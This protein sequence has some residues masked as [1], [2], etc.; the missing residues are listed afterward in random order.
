MA[1]MITVIENVLEKCFEI[2]GE[3]ADK[4]IEYFS[5][6]IKAINGYW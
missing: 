4:K 3:E 2:L 5:Q 1:P 6:R